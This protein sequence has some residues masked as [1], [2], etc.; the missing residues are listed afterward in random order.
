MYFFHVGL[1]HHLWNYYSHQAVNEFGVFLDHL[2]LT[3]FA[4][5]A[6][7]TSVCCPV[8]TG[9]LVVLWMTNRE[10]LH[11]FVESE[12]LGKWG[13]KIIGHWFW[14]KINK[15][16]Q[17]VSSIVCS[18]AS[19]LNPHNILRSRLNLMSTFQSYS[20]ICLNWAPG[21]CL[22]SSCFNRFELKIMNGRLC[23]APQRQ[24]ALWMRMSILSTEID[25]ACT[26]FG[27]ENL[28]AK[29]VIQDKRP[30]ISFHINQTCCAGICSS[31]CLW[32]PD[33]CCTRWLLNSGKLAKAPLNL[34][35][36]TSALSETLPR[37]S[38]EKAFRSK[39]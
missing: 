28:K 35:S 19:L 33:P 13:L 10:K 25:T 11:R 3:D 32:A 30:S 5:S 24:K 39:D 17:P 18:S 20:L 9:G 37:C 36:S 14:Q 15:S 16:G 27:L 38:L 8:Q 7:E 21:Q 2:A 4:I 23:F 29:N 6:P 22:E 12:L 26:W 1:L 31:P 34:F